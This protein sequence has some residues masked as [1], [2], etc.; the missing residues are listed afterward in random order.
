MR[1]EVKETSDEISEISKKPLK[2][3]K[4]VMFR[5]NGNGGVNIWSVDDNKVSF[6]AF[7][8]LVELMVLS[9]KNPGADKRRYERRTPRNLI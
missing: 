3:I 7:K 4:D 8:I 1:I 9:Y 2:D 5:V 6:R